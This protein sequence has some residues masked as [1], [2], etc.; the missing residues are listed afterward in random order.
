M[1]PYMHDAVMWF[2]MQYFINIVIKFKKYIELR[3]ND[4]VTG[5]NKY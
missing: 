2:H 1:T 5:P 3:E 4:G